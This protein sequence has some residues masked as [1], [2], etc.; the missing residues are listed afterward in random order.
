MMVWTLPADDARWKRSPCCFQLTL[1]W[2][3][4]FRQSHGYPRIHQSNSSVPSR[5]QMKRE[6]TR[7][8]ECVSPVELFSRP[9]PSLQMGLPGNHGK[10]NTKR[11][12][13]S[14]R[15]DGHRKKYLFDMTTKI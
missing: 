5:A 14:C 6:K 7:F 12:D 4:Y 13:P 10:K 8:G 2:T 3:V 1:F 9:D 15:Y 11:D